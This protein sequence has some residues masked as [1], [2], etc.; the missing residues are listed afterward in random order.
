M[1]NE[2]SLDIDEPDAKP[3]CQ[4]QSETEVVPITKF[5]DLSIVDEGLR[6]DM[7]HR[8]RGTFIIINNMTFQPQ[9]KQKY[10]DG[11]GIDADN[12]K[13]DFTRLGFD[14]VVYNDQTVGEMLK[15]MI[16]AAQ[17]DHTD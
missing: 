8:R 13:A 3:G 16:T 4:D 12:L 6:Y 9:T 7:N 1:S 5:A 2:L 10:R 14:V 15:L 17:D 11:S